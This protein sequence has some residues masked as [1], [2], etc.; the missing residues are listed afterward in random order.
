VQRWIPGT[1]PLDHRDSFKISTKK[2][3]IH[4]TRLRAHDSVVR[5]IVLVEI[6]CVITTALWSRGGSAVVSVHPPLIHPRL[7]WGQVQ[8]AV[9][10]TVIVW[11]SGAQVKRESSVRN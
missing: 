8:Y 6:Y 9:L 2:S 11:G 5:T 7:A 3:R 1:V 10:L 4:T